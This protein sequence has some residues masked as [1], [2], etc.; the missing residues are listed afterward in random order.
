MTF[1]LTFKQGM[2]LRIKWSSIKGSRLCVIVN[3][4]EG[5]VDVYE[6]ATSNNQIYGVVSYS[7]N[8]MHMNFMS[9]ISESFNDDER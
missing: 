3:V 2:V 1:K 5:L 4:S 8:Y 7:H 9:I 6:F